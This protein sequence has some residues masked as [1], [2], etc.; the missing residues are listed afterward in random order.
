MLGT[1][2]HPEALGSSDAKSELG[3]NDDFL[4]AT[5]ES[6]AEQLFVREGAIHLGGIEERHAEIDRAMNRGDRF[7]FVAWPVKLAHPHASEAESAYL[8]PL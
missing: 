7:V 8:E 5:F 2:V 3:G 6:A 1:A 4:A